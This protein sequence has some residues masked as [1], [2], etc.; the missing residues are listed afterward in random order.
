MTLNRID[1]TQRIHLMGFGNLYFF[2]LLH[3]IKE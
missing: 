1:W 3:G 2:E